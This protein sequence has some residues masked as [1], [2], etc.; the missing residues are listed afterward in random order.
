MLAY[1]FWHRPHQH[2]DSK[3]YESAMIRF[4]AE[5]MRRPPP[6]LIG[7]WSHHIDAVPWLGDQPGYMSNQGVPPGT[8]SIGAADYVLGSTGGEQQVWGDRSWMALLFAPL[9]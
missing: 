7:A 3:A 8:K 6:G 9:S 4:Q 5:L 1:V 2:I